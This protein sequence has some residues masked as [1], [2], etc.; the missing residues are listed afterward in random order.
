MGMFDSFYDESDRE[1]QTKALA[2]DL[3]VY[4]IGD[5]IGEG[6]HD[7]QLEVIGPC[8]HSRWPRWDCAHWVTIRGGRVAEVGVDRD[9]SLFAMA[10]SGGP[11]ITRTTPAHDP[12]EV[13]AEVPGTAGGAL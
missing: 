5:R 3:D 10:Y 9:P 11:A 7:W 4:R 2:C 13:P 1:W 6:A 8:G 12:A